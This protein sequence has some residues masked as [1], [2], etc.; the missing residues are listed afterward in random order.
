VEVNQ[1]GLALCRIR[2]LEEEN[3]V[4]RRAAAHLPWAIL[5]NPK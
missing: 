5:R 4:L 2:E 1:I 3:E